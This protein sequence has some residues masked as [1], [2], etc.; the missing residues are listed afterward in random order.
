M[1]FVCSRLT[2]AMFSISQSNI[3]FLQRFATR[4]I[5]KWLGS[6]R[7]TAALQAY[8]FLQVTATKGCQVHLS[9]VIKCTW[10]QS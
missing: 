4:Q 6:R 10:A 8:H 1:D 2:L 9:G 7:F 3:N 5:T